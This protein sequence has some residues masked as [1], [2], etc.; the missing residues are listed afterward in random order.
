MKY[1]LFPILL[2]PVYVVLV[3]VGLVAGRGEWPRENIRRGGEQ[4][5]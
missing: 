4:W 2:L 3:L 1:L 5:R